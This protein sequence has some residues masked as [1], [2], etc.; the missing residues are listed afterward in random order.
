MP[1]DD[2]P[3]HGDASDADERG[4]PT[5]LA[6]DD[7]Q[8]LAD[9]YAIWLRDDYD[10]RTAYDGESALET[11][12]DAV[13]VVLLD[14]RMPDMSGG[15]VLDRIREAGY[16]VRVS[17]LTAVEPDVDIVDM[18]FDEYL[19]KPVTR[20][21]VV[22][23]VERL[24]A[25][26]DYDDDVQEYFAVSEKVATLEAELSP[27]ERSESDEYQRLADRK[28][29]LEDVVDEELMEMQDFEDAFREI[30]G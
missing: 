18:G 26:A 9:T 22:D 15:E 17:M 13:D 27:E 14:R 10:V 21:D 19:V 1:S 20:E 23:V 7:D 5:V 24:L 25:R 6:V 8:D 11:I 4:L 28:T 30:E 2:D 3:G 16:D 29:E 12:D